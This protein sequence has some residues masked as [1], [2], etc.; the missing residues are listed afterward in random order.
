MILN[1]H[2]YISDRKK[3]MKCPK[4]TSKVSLEMSIKITYRNA[5]K[6]HFLL[7]KQFTTCAL[8]SAV[9]IQILLQL[10][11][12]RIKAGGSLNFW[13]FNFLICKMR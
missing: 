4:I 9:L 10:L 2:I 1:I 12:K 3:V 11:I 13:V 6:L 7:Q 8:E 5:F